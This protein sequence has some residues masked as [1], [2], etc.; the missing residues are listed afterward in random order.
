[1]LIYELET[2]NMIKIL[3]TGVGDINDFKRSYQPGTNIA[4]DKK[5]FWLQTPTVFWLG[6]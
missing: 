4:K 5:G 2:N 3:G 1:V 6:D